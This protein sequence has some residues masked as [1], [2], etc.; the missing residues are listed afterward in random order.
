VLD[1]QRNLLDA[2]P[3]FD[4][5]LAA[6]G[7]L[8]VLETLEINQAV[9]LVAS[10]EGARIARG[11]V[12]PDAEFQVIGDASVETVKAVAQEVDVVLVIARRATR[13]CSTGAEKMRG[14]VGGRSQ[15][16]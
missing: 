3:T 9:D 2:Q 13:K 8:D 1:D 15:T 6:D 5:S 10:S 12:L 7:I 11:L 4:L 14:W 16:N